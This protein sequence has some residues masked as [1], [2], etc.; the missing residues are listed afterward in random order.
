MVGD[1][2]AGG[3][4]QG[5]QSSSGANLYCQELCDP[6]EDN[7]YAIAMDG[8]QVGVSNFI[9]PSWFNPQATKALNAPFDYLAKLT[10]PFTMTSGGYMIVAALDNET[11]VTARHVFGETMPAWRKEYVKG[12]LYRR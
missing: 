7:T 8:Y 11:Q 2:F 10:A 4:S 6:V 12:E 5:P 9:F 1:R 3:F